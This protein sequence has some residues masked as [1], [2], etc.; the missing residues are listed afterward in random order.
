M[1]CASDPPIHTPPQV[2]K[3]YLPIPAGDM[4]ATDAARV[5]A[6]AG[7]ASLALGVATRSPALLAT[8]AASL[9]LGLAYS[10]DHPLL[11]WKRFPAAAAGCILAVRAVIV[12][13]GFY[14]HALAAASLP[15]PPVP[16]TPLVFAVAMMLV[17]SIAIALLKDVPD[18][19]GD[20]AAG[21]RTLTVRAGA[22]S[23]LRG[24]SAL[25]TTAYAT[26]IAFALTRPPGPARLVAAVAHA[27]V[28]AALAVGAARVDTSSPAATYKFYMRVWTAFYLEYMLVPLFR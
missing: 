21:V 13:A 17:F 5:S 26:A 12:Q 2:N 3:P 8:L 14:A 25:L 20:A 22:A 16:P 23:V 9:A 24:A 11:R 10:A 7:A 15:L 6:A 1:T 19:A 28:G 18:A 4:T 27:A